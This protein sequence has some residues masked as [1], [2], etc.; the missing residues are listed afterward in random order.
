MARYVDS[1]IKTAQW[2]KS[3]E[4]LTKAEGN[5][6]QT[7]KE[8]ALNLGG[9]AAA[10]SSSILHDTSAQRLET[11]ID[12]NKQAPIENASQAFT[13][14]FD[15]Q[16]E[17]AKQ[18]KEEANKEQEQKQLETFINVQIRSVENYAN[19]MKKYG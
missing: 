4:N 17:L 8:V 15:R 2:G 18:L 7:Q 11:L 16:D 19:Q 14:S 6:Q 12:A 1:Q 10:N 5:L 13:S 9:E 3:Y